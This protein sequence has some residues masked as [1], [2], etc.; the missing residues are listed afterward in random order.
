VTLLF[1]QNGMNGEVSYV[2]PND[3]ELEL[4]NCLIFLFRL[5]SL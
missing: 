3:I 2:A 5:T 1:V 4:G